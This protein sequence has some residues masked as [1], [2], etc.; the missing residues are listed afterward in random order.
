VL[1]VIA[2][3]VGTVVL[4]ISRLHTHSRRNWDEQRWHSLSYPQTHDV[5]NSVLFHS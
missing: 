3:E 1:E 5:F 2:E 4:L